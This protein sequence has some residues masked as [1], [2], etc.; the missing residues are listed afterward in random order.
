[1]SNSKLFLLIL[2]ATPALADNVCNGKNP[3]ITPKSIVRVKYPD[4]KGMP[5]DLAT[6]KKA[7]TVEVVRE[8]LKRGFYT[9]FY[10][11][12]TWQQR[13]IFNAAVGDLK[14]DPVVDSL[15]KNYTF[16]FP[17]SVVKKVFKKQDELDFQGF[18]YD[19]TD[20]TWK[21]S[22]AI[23]DSDWMWRNYA[24]RMTTVSEAPKESGEIVFQVELDLGLFCQTAVPVSSLLSSN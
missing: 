4:T 21:A 15:M 13:D 6:K 19:Y 23:E 18:G 22:K 12:D 7:E 24:Y 9:R 16:R 2:L 3:R 14:T 17:L 10:F 1:M 20:L 8:F 5:V 11:N